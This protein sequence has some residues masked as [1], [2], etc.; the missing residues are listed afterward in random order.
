MT[1]IDHYYNCILQMSF[2]LNQLIDR[3]HSEK[4]LNDLCDV[5]YSEGGQINQIQ[6]NAALKVI[7]PF[8][9]LRE[10][11]RKLMNKHSLGNLAGLEFQGTPGEP[12]YA[13]GVVR[14]QWLICPKD[15]EK[16]W[17]YEI[18]VGEKRLCLKHRVFFDVESQAK[19]GQSEK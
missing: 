6:I 19:T 13:E 5:L 9:P 17:D 14:G 15:G 10:R 16:I 11:V 8:P 7:S 1:R 18:S 4:I 12:I 3:D 2:D